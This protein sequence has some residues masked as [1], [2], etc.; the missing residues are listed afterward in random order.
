VLRPIARQR[1]FPKGRRIEV[2][3]QS[4]R[5]GC[6]TMRA[7]R[8]WSFAGTTSRKSYFLIGTIA[9]LVKSSVDHIVAAYFFDRPWGLLNYWFPF[10]SLARP[11]LLRGAEANLSLALLALSFPFIWLGVA[12]TV[13][14]LNDCEQPLWLSVLFFVPFVNLVFFAVLCCW[15]PARRGGMVPGD[16]VPPYRASPLERLFRF[17]GGAI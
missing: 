17:A 16:L 6:A 2:L 1:K 11:W 10:P 9:F 7:L 4:E 14:R 5:W 3:F 15:P 12:Q 8:L 13:R